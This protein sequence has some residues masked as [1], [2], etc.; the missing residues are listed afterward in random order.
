MDGNL[1]NPDTRVGD[2][3]SHGIEKIPGLEEDEKERISREISKYSHGD[4]I[5]L[6]S[7]DI[8]TTKQNIPELL[9]RRFEDFQVDGKKCEFLTYTVIGNKIEENSLSKVY[10]WYQLI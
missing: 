7:L 5:Y 8:D 1:N 3:L 4:H 10:Y 6:D 2:D 9:R